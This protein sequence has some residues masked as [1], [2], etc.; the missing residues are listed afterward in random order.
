MMRLLPMLFLLT[1]CASFAES[2]QT[3]DINLTITWVEDYQVYGVTGVMFSEGVTQWYDQGDTRNCYI[4]MKKPYGPK[5][6]R[7]IYILGHEL[8]HCTEGAYH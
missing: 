5:D 2:E 7:Q 8:L 6:Y 4:F 3:D 1:G